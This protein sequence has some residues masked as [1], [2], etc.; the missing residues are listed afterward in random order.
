MYTWI[1]PIEF[2]LA[3]IVIQ[4]PQITHHE[5]QGLGILLGKGIN[6]NINW[7]EF[8]R[9]IEWNLNSIQTY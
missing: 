9:G 6:L 3:R 4:I 2:L 7:T 8:D 5:I 1:L